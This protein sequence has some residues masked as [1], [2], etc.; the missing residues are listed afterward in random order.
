MCRCDMHDKFREW[1]QT[2]LTSHLR[3][4]IFLNSM[5]Q[6]QILKCEIWDYIR[7]KKW[8][9]P[10]RECHV[11]KFSWHALIFSLI[12]KMILPGKVNPTPRTVS[13]QWHMGARFRRFKRIR[14]KRSPTWQEIYVSVFYGSV[15]YGS[16]KNGSVSNLTTPLEMTLSIEICKTLIQNNCTWVT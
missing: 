3:P 8:H 11:L 2:P 13:H 15:F 12:L 4:T 14:L 7:V 10:Q 5:F 16:V 6:S 9:L 1:H